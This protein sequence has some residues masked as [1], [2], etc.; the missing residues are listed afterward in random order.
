MMQ[1][2]LQFAHTNGCAPYHATSRSSGNEK[3]GKSTT[4]PDYH[5]N[6]VRAS[7]ERPT[8]RSFPVSRR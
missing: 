6:W 5:L 1:D 3:K 7:I 8:L 4:V 2:S